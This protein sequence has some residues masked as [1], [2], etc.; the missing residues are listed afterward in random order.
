MLPRAIYLVGRQL[1]RLVRWAVLDPIR[2][3]RCTRALRRHAEDCERCAFAE[4]YGMGSVA[5]CARGAGIEM[6]RLEGRR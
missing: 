6:R 5:M 4:D 1:I 3:L 2:D